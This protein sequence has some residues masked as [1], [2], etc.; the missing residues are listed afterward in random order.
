MYGLSV[1]S[2]APGTAK[3]LGQP[4][5]RAIGSTINPERF[6]DTDF[7]ESSWQELDPIPNAVV[8][9]DKP[10]AIANEAGRPYSQDGALY[11]PRGADLRNGDRFD[12]QGKT[13]GV[14]GDAR[15]DMEHPLTGNDLGYV[16]YSIRLGG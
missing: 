8:A 7:G 2:S 15:W 9:L 6:T 10:V 3:G 1:S 5:L 4:D 14:V 13:F 11:V 12:Y 16:E